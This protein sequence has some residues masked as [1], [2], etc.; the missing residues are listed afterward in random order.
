[1]NGYCRRCRRFIE[2]HKV[3][4]F[5]KPIRRFGIRFLLNGYGT[6]ENSYE[7]CDECYDELMKFWEG[8]AIEAVTYDDQCPHCG[9]LMQHSKFCSE[10]GKEL[11]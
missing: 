11:R 5:E 8:K 10:C 1:M 6:V 3:L 7:I 4:W 9:A 2:R